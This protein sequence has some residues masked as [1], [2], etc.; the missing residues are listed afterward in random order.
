MTEL[1][2][3]NAQSVRQ[4]ERVRDYQAAHYPPTGRTRG[5]F[6]KRASRLP[7][8]DS[9]T[10][11]LEQFAH[12]GRLPFYEDESFDKDDWHGLLLGLG[13]MP[14]IA[15]PIASATAPGTIAATLKRLAEATA[16]LPARLPLPRLS[17]ATGAWPM[18]DP[19]LGP[20]RK[21]VIVGGGTAWL[22]GRCCG[23][24]LSRRWPAPDRSD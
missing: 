21:V 9:L 15:D 19:N 20:I 3:Y 16:A 8:P 2:E 10:H 23:C 22:D 24:P 5:A 7:R 1:A 12:R 17:R 11:T 13:M 14:H 6:W 18:T 4:A